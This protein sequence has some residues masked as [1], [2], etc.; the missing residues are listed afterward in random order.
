[1]SV[2]LLSAPVSVLLCPLEPLP[3]PTA[4]GPD[5]ADTSERCLLDLNSVLPL[6]T[7][8]TLLGLPCLCSTAATAAGDF[9][10][11]SFSS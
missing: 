4:E 6:Q 9:R 11:G 3:L 1:M 8:S 2:D 10:P 7:T 5:A